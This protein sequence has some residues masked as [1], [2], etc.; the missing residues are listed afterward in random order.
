M[1]NIIITED[2]IGLPPGTPVY[3]GDRPASAMDI[4]VITYNASH[5]EKY[6]ISSIDELSSCKNN[7]IMWV[8]INGLKEI[9]ELN[10]LAAVY[11]I[12]SLT[13]EDVLNTKQQPKFETFADYSFL[14]FKSIQHEA[15]PVT[16]EEKQKQSRKWFKKKIKEEEREEEITIDQISLII[17]KNILIT[18]QEI[19]GDP[20]GSIRKRISENIGQIRK[21]GTD[22]LAYSLIDAVVDVYYLAFAGLEEDIEIFEDRAIKTSNDTFI[23]DIQDTKK[24]LFQ[25]KRAILPLR[26]NLMIISHQGL[27]FTNNEL[28]PFLQD[29]HENLNNAIEIVENYREWLTNIVDVNLSVLSYQMNKVMKILATVSAIF[30]PLTFIVGIYGMNFEYMPELSRPWAYPMVLIIMGCIAL[31]MVVFFKIRKWF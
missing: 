18:F 26:E 2:N 15:K 20:F 10:K 11:N 3:V 13:I 5:A 23:A 31:G 7:G 4:S 9:D 22:Y 1:E 17:M 8:N 19:P 24:E 14:S 16:A 28:K 25:I 6:K 29:L 21:K 30:I 27:P 12:H